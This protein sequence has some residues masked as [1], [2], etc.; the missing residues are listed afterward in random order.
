MAKS[1]STL[2][3]LS[4]DD[5]KK[6]A[7]VS[8]KLRQDYNDYLGWLDKKGLKGHPSLDKN[9]LGGQMIDQYQKETPNTSVNRAA[10]VP[11]QQELSKYRDYSINQLR[12]GKAQLSDDKTPQGRFVKPNENLDN[13][14]KNLSQ[15]DGIAGQK[16]TS[17]AF[18]LS[19]LKTFDTNNNLISNENKGF[20]TVPNQAQIVAKN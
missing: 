3:T 14:M 12:T 19:Y 10:I 15:V 9:D 2:K 20:S 17:T 11:I 1:L 6:S 16:T 8:S 7:E 18:P 5:P 4:E 13:Y